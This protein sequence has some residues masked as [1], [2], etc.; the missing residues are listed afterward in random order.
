MKPAHLTEATF[1]KTIAEAD[2][3]LVDFWADWCGP[4]LQFAGVFEA[5]SAANPDIVFA[6][7]DTEAEVY[8]A[9][10]SNITSIPTLLAFREGLLVFEEAGALPAAELDSVIEVVRGL[11]MA[12]VTAESTKSQR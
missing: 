1:A 9:Q 5:D 3:V 8:L 10:S 12:A 2:I 7:V 6:K 4:C 11:D